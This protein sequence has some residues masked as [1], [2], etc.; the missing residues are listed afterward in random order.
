MISMKRF[1]L[2][3]VSAALLVSGTLASAQTID[4]VPNSHSIP[5]QARYQCLAPSATV[6]SVDVEWEELQFTYT[7][8]GTKTWNPQTHQYHLEASGQWSSKGNQFTVTNHSNASVQVNFDFDSQD[9]HVT[10]SF[11][12]PLLSLPTA[13]E[14]PVDDPQLTGVSALSLS[15]EYRGSSSFSRIGA[16]TV[17]IQP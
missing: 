8:T 16:V 1:V 4:S 10:G 6:Y 12:N 5:V 3:A 9:N 17:T 2:L 7:H 14:K 15:G 11:S 13:E